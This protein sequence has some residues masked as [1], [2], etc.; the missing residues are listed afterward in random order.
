MDIID[1]SY[2]ETIED[3]NKTHFNELFKLENLDEYKKYLKYEKIIDIMPVTT[4][5]EGYGNVSYNHNYYYILT[6]YG[7]IHVFDKISDND[8]KAVKINDDDHIINVN[9]II[10]TVIRKGT[11]IIPIH[12]K[13]LLQSFMKGSNRA[14]LSNVLWGNCQG[15]GQGNNYHGLCLEKL[16]E[17]FKYLVIIIDMFERKNNEDILISEELYKL[18]LDDKY[19]LQNTMNEL[20]N[21]FDERT[22]IIDKQMNELKNKQK[23]LDDEKREFEK[24]KSEFNEI[25]SKWEIN[26]T[27]NSINYDKKELELIE[28]NNDLEI[29]N[30]KLNKMEFDIKSKINQYN[31]EIDAIN[32]IKVNLEQDK[33]KNEEMNKKNSEEKDVLIELQK[34]VDIKLAQLIIQREEHDNEKQNMQKIKMKLNMEQHKFEKMKSKYETYVEELIGIKLDDLI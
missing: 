1:E 10:L 23:N 30:L 17:Y 20:T 34:D 18:H 6:N 9:N 7:S 8:Y 29:Y 24:I 12:Y 4:L 15:V 26:K 19:K 2:I 27:M 28:K 16:R 25:K 5:T 31:V 3:L 32:I 22:N 33:I 21:N 14:L 11:S 13:T